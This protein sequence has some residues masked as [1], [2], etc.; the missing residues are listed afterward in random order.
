[1]DFHDRRHDR[2]AI[3]DGISM[4]FF[5]ALGRLICIVVNLSFVICGLQ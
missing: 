5:I 1:M 3:G 4:I 2:A